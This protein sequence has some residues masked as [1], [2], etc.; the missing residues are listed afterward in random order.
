MIKQIIFKIKNIFKRKLNKNPLTAIEEG[1]Q[2]K[3]CL[4]CGSKNLQNKTLLFQPNSY[5]CKDCG[6][7]FVRIEQTD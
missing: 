4:F 5:V 1:G 7:L 6:S 2:V 3:V